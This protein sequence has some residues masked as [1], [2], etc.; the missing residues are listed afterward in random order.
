MELSEIG[1][2]VV[3]ELL[4]IF[5]MHLDMNLWMGEYILM[6]NHFHVI[7]GIEDTKY[8]IPSPSCFFS[9][10][11]HGIYTITTNAATKPD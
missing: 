9:D 3:L 2:I 5:T 4:K 10:A 7:I 8:T 11:M 6:P 1:I